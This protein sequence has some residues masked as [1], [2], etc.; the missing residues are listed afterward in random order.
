M[1]RDQNEKMTD[2][3]RGMYEKQTGYVE[4]L[5]Y[6][7]PSLSHH[8]PLTQIQ[9]CTCIPNSAPQLFSPTLQSPNSIQRSLKP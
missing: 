8:L 6:L 1:S 9:T 5:P 7:P 2:A 4:L 3:A